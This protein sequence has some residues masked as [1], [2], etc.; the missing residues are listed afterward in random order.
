MI[1]RAQRQRLYSLFARIWWGVLTAI[2]VPILAK[3]CVSLASQG[4]NPGLVGSAVGL[5]LTL[6][7]FLLKIWDVRI[8][9]LPNRKHSFLTFCLIVAFVHHDVRSV[10][11]SNP[12]L[13]QATVIAAS[14]VL[15]P[16]LVLAT[17]NAIRV[18]IPPQE[19]ITSL[20]RSY[21]RVRWELPP[22]ISLLGRISLLAPRAPPA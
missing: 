5:V 2:H 7:F 1:P 18:R 9:R 15:L 10:A 8:L 21:D 13:A 16:R 4:P 22:P 6:G 3:V 17:K 20:A 12:A 19:G 11:T 14:A